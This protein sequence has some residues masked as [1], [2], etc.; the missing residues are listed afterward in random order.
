MRSFML[1]GI[2][3]MLLFAG[4]TM[5]AVPLITNNQTQQTC[6]MVTEQKPVTT[7]QCG[8]VSTTEQVCGI[9]KLPYDATVLPRIDLCIL[10]GM[11]VG[12]PLSDC[13]AC[14]NAMTRCTLIIEN[15][16]PQKSGTW[17]V[18]ANYTLR[19]SGFNKDPITATIKPNE[20]FAFDFQ[21]MYVPGDPVTSAICNI[22]ILS[23]ATV[24]DCHDETR[25]KSECRNVTTMSTVQR[26]V[27]N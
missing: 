6:H 5:P 8:E 13:P 17:T 21:Q 25:T 18:G 4:C 19:N 10:D 9:R 14:S 12:K 26:Q 3:A 11:C 24:D 7:E 1:L 20:T 15:E 27:C 16:D 22:Y 23:E 2:F